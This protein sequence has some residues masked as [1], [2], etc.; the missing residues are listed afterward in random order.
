MIP[1]YTD[2]ACSK[3]GYPD[4]KAGIGVFFCDNDERNISEA[5][6]K[7]YKQTNN[8]AELLAFI[9]AIKIVKDDGKRYTIYTDSEYVIKC[10]T[11]FK[12][13]LQKKD[14]SEIKNFELV[15]ELYKLVEQ[16]NI[17]Y[18]HIR[19][20]TGLSDEHSYG[21]EQADKLANNSIGLEV[22]KRICLSI[23]FESKDNAKALGAKWDKDIKHWFY[24]GSDNDII[25]KLKALE[26]KEHH[27]NISFGNKDTAKGLGA[28]WDASV[29]KWYYTD[30]M[31]AEKIAKLLKLST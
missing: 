5:V 20:H 23:P 4:A 17:K 1:I 22:V 28:K 15:S 18:E 29:K 26:V 6:D 2:G 31:D 8:V 10:A 7:S 9:K 25:T 24:E 27:L 13:W 14:K 30:N 12:K 19:A 21:N 16:N 11:N 3:N